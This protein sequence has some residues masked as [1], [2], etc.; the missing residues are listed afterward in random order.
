VYLLLFVSGI[1]GL[2]N[3]GPTLMSPALPNPS[4]PLPCVSVYATHLYAPCERLV[5]QLIGN[6]NFSS[7]HGILSEGHTQRWK[8]NA[9]GTMFEV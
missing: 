3:D 5:R 1:G 8:G 2:A 4:L 9:I 6:H 7:E